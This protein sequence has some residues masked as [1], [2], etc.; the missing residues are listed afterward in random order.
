MTWD[1]LDNW[2]KE[3]VAYSKNPDSE[4]MKTP[5]MFYFMY[6]L[7]IPGLDQLHLQW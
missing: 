7:V 2:M 3:A 6:W 4:Y 1:E 5:I